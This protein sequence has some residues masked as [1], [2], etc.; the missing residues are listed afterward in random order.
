MINSIQ[1]DK[2]NFK[3]D[4]IFLLVA[5]KKDDEV[6]EPWGQELTVYSKTRVPTVVKT[7]TKN[8]LNET[9]KE[10]KEILNKND[11][12]N[13]ALVADRFLVNM[14]NA[15]VN[16]HNYLGEYILGVDFNFGPSVSLFVSSDKEDV[17]NIMNEYKEQEEFYLQNNKGTLV[18]DANPEQT[19]EENNTLNE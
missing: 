8:E 5:S 2:V 1:I 4:D 19:E 18:L 16:I 12:Y 3:I 9:L 15:S 10:Y 6:C 7:G 13:F 17:V 14:D 11:I